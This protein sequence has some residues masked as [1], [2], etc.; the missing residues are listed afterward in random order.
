[1]NQ[2]RVA[3]RP[4]AGFN[5]TIL[6]FSDNTT[7]TITFADSGSLLTYN[8]APMRKISWIN[9]SAQSVHGS[10]TG[11]IEVQVYGSKEIKESQVATNQHKGT[12]FLFNVSGFTPEGALLT[13][14][15]VRR[16]TNVTVDIRVNDQNF[17][18]GLEKLQWYNGSLWVD[19]NIS[20]KCK[21]TLDQTETN[22]SAKVI[23]GKVW[24]ACYNDTNGNSKKDYFKV[25]LPDVGN[26]QLRAVSFTEI[27]IL[28]E[29]NYP[30]IVTYNYNET[31]RV[32]VNET[33]GQ[34]VI[35]K[36]NLT[37]IFK[38]A[39]TKT[40]TMVSGIGG[41]PDLWEYNYTFLTSDYVGRVNVTVQTYGASGEP[42]AGG[43][44][45][46]VRYIPT[47]T[48][49]IVTTNGILKTKTNI[50]RYSYRDYTLTY[51]T[52]ET[53]TD[54]YFRLPR[55]STIV[56]AQMN[57]TGLSNPVGSQAYY[58]TNASVNINAGGAEWS[59]VGSYSTS[60]IVTNLTSA[61]QAYLATHIEDSSGFVNVPISVYSKT[62]GKIYLSDVSVY[63]TINESALFNV[64]LGWNNQS[65]VA[66]DAPVGL[67]YEYRKRT[68]QTPKADFTLKGYKI[69]NGTS[70]CKINGTQRSIYKMENDYY[71]RL[72]TSINL[73]T[74]GSGT[75]KTYAVLTDKSR[76]SPAR[77]MFSEA[78]V[79]N[80]ALADNGGSVSAYSSWLW[81]YDN[82]IDGSISDGSSYAWASNDASP[83][84]T[85][86]F[87]QSYYIKTIK[88]ANRPGAGFNRVKLTFSD[89]STKSINLSNTTGTGNTT[90]QTI[91][92]SPHLKTS[93]I[94]ISSESVY[95]A[96][97][98][99][100]EIEVYG[101]N[102]ISQYFSTTGSV[103]VPYLYFNTSV[104]APRLTGVL[105]PTSFSNVTTEV[106]FND[107]NF[108]Q[109]IEEIFWYNGSVW[110]ALNATKRCQN[111]K[112]GTEL[113]YSTKVINSKVWK[114]CYNDTNDN[115]KVDYYKILIPSLVSQQFR[116][117]AFTGIN[118]LDEK[119]YPTV[120]TYFVN[121]T[122]R[123]RANETYGQYAIQSVN[124]SLIFS[125]QT[126]KYQMVNNIGGK[127]NLWEY[128]YTVKLSDPLGN[129]TIKVTAYGGSGNVLVTDT[130]Q[131]YYV[132]EK[133]EL[134]LLNT[135]GY[136]FGTTNLF[137]NDNTDNTATFSGAGSDSSIRLYL[138]KLAY[139]ISARL[140]VIGVAH[141]VGAT[142]YYPANVTLNIGGGAV[143]WDHTGRLNHSHT[144]G[145]L[146][147]AV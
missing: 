134:M 110:V 130:V 129:F 126:R 111:V 62:R 12:D 74:S 24:R 23:A 78:N 87:N 68:G 64:S 147:L 114:A 75:Y 19:L 102:T 58:P 5:R 30:Q 133:R 104:F 146:G 103:I 44:I 3:N 73:S 6:Y 85:L 125:N 76:G 143:E 11:F 56:Y 145:D 26:E 105:N 14:G 22:Y 92:I 132:N 109:G 97:A 61:I 67:F 53:K 99:F 100:Q 45:T 119:Y 93:W 112:S 16:F 108:T 52:D 1:V 43:Y 36:V 70:W 113:N 8:I 47:N 66:V 49:T 10:F 90:F 86:L 88:F 18:Q 42:L 39:S 50:F 142:T 32:R 123:I 77:N 79:R 55:Y 107:T 118:I 63:Y 141:T 69:E 4:G 51:T 96:N 2:I 27:N 84:I 124:V 80:I 40:Y 46:G 139:N 35:T 34:N 136:V 72:A 29:L 57:V 81:D 138:P 71:C 33:F 60:T 116:V 120:Q 91:N 21:K 137:S 15:S 31:L 38:D 20:T 9:I 89:G 106:F 48:T 131:D 54:V 101:T 82:V 140:K 98:G 121:N 135:S 95:G 59:Y 37:L 7:Q 41:N 65:N 94:N 127:Q 13:S 128:N 117:A 17:T 83:W 115:G 28:D 144:T 25:L 122:L